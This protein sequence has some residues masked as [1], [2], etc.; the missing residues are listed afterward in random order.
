VHVLLRLPP[1]GGQVNC[2]VCSDDVSLNPEPEN[3][4]AASS[5]VFCEYSWTPGDIVQAEDRAHRIGQVR[6]HAP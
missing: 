4:Q 1:P 3:A 6:M 5:C 2:S